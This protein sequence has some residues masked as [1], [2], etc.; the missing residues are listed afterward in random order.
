MRAAK[1]DPHEEDPG[2]TTRGFFARKSTGSTSPTPFPPAFVPPT[3]PDPAGSTDVFL[4]KN[5]W[6]GGG[7]GGPFRPPSHPLGGP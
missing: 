5:R 6:G 3:Y 2:N 7:G 4:T 1:S